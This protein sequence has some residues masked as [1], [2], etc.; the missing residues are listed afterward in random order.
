MNVQDVRQ[1]QV[2]LDAPLF[3]DLKRGCLWTFGQKI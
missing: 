1:N 3:I 2:D